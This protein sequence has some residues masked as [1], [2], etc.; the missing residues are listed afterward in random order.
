ME[1]DLMLKGYELVGEEDKVEAAVWEAVLPKVQVVYADA[2][3]VGIQNH[4]SLVC[5]VIIKNVRNAVHQ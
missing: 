3:I 4:M 2:Q 1:Q 5:L